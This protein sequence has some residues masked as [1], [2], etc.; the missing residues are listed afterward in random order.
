MPGDHTADSC[1]LLQT[2]FFSAFKTITLHSQAWQITDD[3]APLVLARLEAQN[4][5]TVRFQ[6]SKGM[7]L[8][9]LQHSLANDNNA[10]QLMMS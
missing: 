9:Q 10:F 7:M 6:G 4:H 1:N 3:V 8:L 2:M 5:I